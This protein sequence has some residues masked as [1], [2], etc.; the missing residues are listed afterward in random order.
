MIKYLN[1]VDIWFGI[2]SSFFL[3][4]AMSISILSFQFERHYWRFCC[5]K[6]YNLNKTK[7]HLISWFIIITIISK[8]ISNKTFTKN[9]LHTRCCSSSVHLASGTPHTIASFCC[10]WSFDSIVRTH[11]FFPYCIWFQHLSADSINLDIVWSPVALT[12]WGRYS[13]RPTFYFCHSMLQFLPQHLSMCST[14][15]HGMLSILQPLIAIHHFVW[16][17]DPNWRSIVNCCG[18]RQKWLKMKWLVCR[19]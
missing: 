1:S 3:V 12:Y 14:Y 5:L 13:F 9:I 2:F 6:T 8:S 15:C 7:Q 11:W 4:W 17:F 10:R 19:Q 16:T 18:M